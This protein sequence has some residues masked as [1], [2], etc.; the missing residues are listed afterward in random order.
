[1]W[2]Q[3]HHVIGPHCFLLEDGPSSSH[4]VAMMLLQLREVIRSSL[5]RQ[6]SAKV[7]AVIAAELQQ[8]PEHQS[9]E[10]MPIDSDG[11]FDAEIGRH[12]LQGCRPIHL[13]SVFLE[14]GQV[15]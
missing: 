5:R 3:Q 12:W 15:A 9:G 4:G 14:D 6:L 13:S 11:N 2:K 8:L 7:K 1:M 10:E